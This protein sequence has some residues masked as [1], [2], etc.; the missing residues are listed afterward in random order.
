MGNPFDNEEDRSQAFD[1]AV[2]DLLQGVDG[3]RSMQGNKVNGT[4]DRVYRVGRRCLILREDKVE[5]GGAGDAY[6]Q[7]SR[8]Y[9]LA[10]EQMATNGIVP[11]APVFL[12]C[13]VGEWSSS[14]FVS[15]L[16]SGPRAYSRHLRRFQ[17]W[18]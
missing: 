12:L 6:M 5:M 10:C 16:I 18:R 9:D 15:Q 7:V 17:G 4:G 14:L 13:V 1:Q 3:S 2:G 8:L 11:N